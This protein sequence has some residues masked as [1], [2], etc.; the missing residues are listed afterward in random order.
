MDDLRGDTSHL[1]LTGKL[2]ALSIETRRVEQ[3]VRVGKEGRESVY[4]VSSR[5]RFQRDA[6]MSGN[7]S[8]GFFTGT[9]AMTS[10]SSMNFGDT[11]SLS[12]FRR[13]FR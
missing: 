10:G 2:G 11:D 7:T 1:L 4:L 13:M 5:L 3:L 9:S 6:S 8:F 12:L